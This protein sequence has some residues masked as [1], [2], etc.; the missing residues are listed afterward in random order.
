MIKKNKKGWI[1][2][3][4]AFIAVLLIAGVLL[5]V[6]N[7]G[8]IGK[9]DIS[10][11]VYEV[12]LAVLREI[13][14]NSELRVSILAI[15]NESLPVEWENFTTENNLDKVKGKLSERLPDYL[16]CEARICKL[17]SVCPKKVFIEKDIYAQGVAITAE[18]TA[19]EAKYDPR[20]LKLFC[21]TG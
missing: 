17:E 4:E 2:I 5:F 3:V 10:E 14:L 21:W 11:Q 6:I 18:T 19:E 15:D 12:Q 8:Y 7:R 16:T 13:E 9:R 1:R 20:Q